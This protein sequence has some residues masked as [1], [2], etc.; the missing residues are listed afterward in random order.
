[1]DEPLQRSAPLRLVPGRQVRELQA[2]ERASLQVA[3]PLDCHHIKEPSVSDF[4][5]GLFGAVHIV[6][7]EQC[8]ARPNAPSLINNLGLN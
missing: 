2:S 6:L 5:R 7:S 8:E 4:E 3:S 1:M